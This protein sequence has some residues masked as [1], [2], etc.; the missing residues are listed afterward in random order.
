MYIQNATSNAF[1]FLGS[2]FPIF[3]AEAHAIESHIALTLGRP[4]VYRLEFKLC[5]LTADTRYYAHGQ[6]T[7]VTIQRR[8]KLTGHVG[9][10]LDAAYGRNKSELDDIDNDSKKYDYADEVKS[11]VHEYKNDQLFDNIS[12]RQHRSFPN[13]EIKRHIVEPAGLKSRLIKYS[14]KLDLIQ[15]F[16]R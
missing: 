8:S 9:R 16:L 12:G 14:K 15:N 11:F 5:L 1:F 13:F 7:N 10:S 2:V 3:A 4:Y 6:Y